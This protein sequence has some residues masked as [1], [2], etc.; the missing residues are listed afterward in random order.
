MVKNRKHE[1][2][3]IY[4]TDNKYINLDKKSELYLY[5]LKIQNE[6]HRFA[7]TFF[8]QRKQSSLFKSKLQDI[9]EIGSV[10][11]DKLLSNY[12]NITAIKEASIEELS[13]YVGIKKAKIIKEHLKNN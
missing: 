1:T 4:I 7:I 10:S 6:V 12:Q 11:I 3:K 13:Q 9:P 2:E 5:L 8:R